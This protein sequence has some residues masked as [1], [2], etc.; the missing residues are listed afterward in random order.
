M[1]NNGPPEVAGEGD[2]VPAELRENISEEDRELDSYRE[3]ENLWRINENRNPLFKLAL[4][5]WMRREQELDH[6]QSR[7]ESKSI[8]LHT[9]I[10]NIIGWYAVFQGVLLTAV[11][12]LTASPGKV[13]V[14][15]KI[16]YP[17]L[18]TGF[19]TLVTIV[20]VYRLFSDLKSLENTINTEKKARGE[21]AKR[22]STLRTRGLQ[23]FS[24]RKHT[25]NNQEYP[26]QDFWRN[27]VAVIV[28]LLIFTGLFILS[29]FVILCDTWVIRKW[30]NGLPGY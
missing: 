25:S 15:G 6:R 10:H 12:Q 2:H 23:K 20:G 3:I 21:A 28:S 26:Q 1:Q 13:P 27:K 30:D 5:E 19:G 22:V 29:Y 16:W 9:Q 11:S 7:R 14:C 18:L 4:A 8:D 24:F 17:I